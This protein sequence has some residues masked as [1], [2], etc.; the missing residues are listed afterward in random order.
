MP[1]MEG[2]MGMMSDADM[3][4][5]QNA[6]GVDA[7]KLFLQ[8]MIRHHQGAIKMAQNEI[9]TGQYPPAVDL[10]RSIATSQQQEIDTMQGILA[11]L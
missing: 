5:L 7:S 6:R 2:M 1:G 11:S 9:D 3:A 10:A 4:A 8:Q